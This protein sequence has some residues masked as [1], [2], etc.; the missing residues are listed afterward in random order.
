MEMTCCFVELLQR[1][2]KTLFYNSLDRRRADT[3]ILNVLSSA[4]LISRRNGREQLTQAL[5]LSLDTLKSHDFKS[6]I[7]EDALGR[8]SIRL[9]L[10]ALIPVSVV[11]KA[12]SPELW[13]QKQTVS[14]HTPPRSR[15]YT[16][17]PSKIGS[18]QYV[19]TTSGSSQ[20]KL[21]SVNPTL[22]YGVS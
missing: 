2:S 17:A 10:P 13:S 4:S 19:Q 15:L 6:I 3:T 1:P 8:M 12:T 9:P 18:W 7:L 16:L 11:R 14:R 22:E 20:P 5:S 21:N